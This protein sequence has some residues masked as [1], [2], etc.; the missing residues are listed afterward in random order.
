[1]NGEKITVND[2]KGFYDFKGLIDTL[3][4]DCN[5]LPKDL[6]G[7]NNVAFCN[8]LVQMVQKLVNLKDGL[9]A[10]FANREEVIKAKDAE[11]NKLLE[12]M[13]KAVKDA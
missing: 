2:G 10:D 1:M 8:R 13:G 4:L 6:M 12:Q 3:I 5:E 9:I 7:G 11:Y